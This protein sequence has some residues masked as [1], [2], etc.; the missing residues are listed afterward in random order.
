[1]TWPQRSQA[2][3]S[4]RAFK[5]TRNQIELGEKGEGKQ[6]V[7]SFGSWSSIGGGAWGK[8]FIRHEGARHL[9]S[10]AHAPELAWH[11]DTEED[12]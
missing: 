12:I 1:M 5:K 9:R 3:S 6:K 7:Q 10:K 11:G 4:K 2:L 8:S